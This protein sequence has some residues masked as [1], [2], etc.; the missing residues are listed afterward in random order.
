MEYS[1]AFLPVG[2]VTC[3]EVVTFQTLEGLGNL[4]DITQALH[5]I[6]K[7]VLQL[8]GRGWPGAEKR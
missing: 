2:P 4:A 7:L 6:G 1:T 5:G 3:D 8:A